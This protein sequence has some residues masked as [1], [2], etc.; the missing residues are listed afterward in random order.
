MGLII[1]LEH[2][3]QKYQN[4]SDCFIG[5][6]YDKSVESV[7]KAYNGKDGYLCLGDMDKEFNKDSNPLGKYVITSCIDQQASI[8]TIEFSIGIIREQE[9]LTNE[10]SMYHESNTVSN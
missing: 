1:I 8:P 10:K 6:L 9:I 3:D 2:I 7:L 5:S 4:L